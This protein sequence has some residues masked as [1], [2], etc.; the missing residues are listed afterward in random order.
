[1]FLPEEVYK[2]ITLP[3]IA[4]LNTMHSSSVNFKSFL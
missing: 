3:T 2:F 4:T 1:V